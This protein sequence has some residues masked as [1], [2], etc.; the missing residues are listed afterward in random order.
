MS[1]ITPDM[2]MQQ[3]AAQVAAQHAESAQARTQARLDRDAAKVRAEA[4]RKARA[5]RDAEIV[6]VVKQTKPENRNATIERLA[7]KHGINV[8]RVRAIAVEAGVMAKGERVT[9]AAQEKRDAEVLRVFKGKGKGSLRG[10]GELV[11]LP[12]STVYSIVKR[13]GLMEGRTR[14]P[15]ATIT[16][17]TALRLA[18][19]AEE[20]GLDTADLCKA[21]IAGRIEDEATSEPESDQE[22]TGDEGESEGQ[23]GAP[24]EPSE[25]EGEQGEGD[26]PAAE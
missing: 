3:V 4:D 17:T 23:D 10:T 11:G 1:S 22:G 6:R 5:K 24:V 7:Q 2:T 16:S 21:F 8:H 9:G 12:T 20:A 26:A 19:L 18:Q 14:Q 15:A 25:A 13:A